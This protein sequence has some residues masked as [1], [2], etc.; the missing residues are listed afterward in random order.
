MATKNPNAAPPQDPTEGGSFV[1]NTDGSL[2]TVQ[3]TVQNPGRVQR[4]PAAAA[5]AT[6]I[7]KE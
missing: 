7:P 6:D 2:T 1:R 5:P 4:Q 3:Q